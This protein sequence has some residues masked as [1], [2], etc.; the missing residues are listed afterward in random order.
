[1]KNKIHRLSVSILCLALLLVACGPQPSPTAA[2]EPSPAPT[3]PS[4]LPKTDWRLVVIGDSSL[5]RLG[6]AFA[7]QIENDLGVRVTLSDYA[8]P[9]LSA[10][11]VLED[12]RRETPPYRRLSP[13]AIEALRQANAV[14]MFVNPLHSVDPEHPLDTLACFGNRAPAIC[15]PEAFEPYIADLKA[16]WARILELRGD[17]PTILRAT[18]IYNPLVSPWREAGMFD[19]CTD[20]WQNLSDAARLAA[21]AYNIPFLSRFDAFNGPNHDEDPRGKGYIEADGEHPTELAAQFTAELLSQMGYEPVSPPPAPEPTATPQSDAGQTAASPYPLAEP[22]PYFTGKSQDRRSRTPA[23][24]TAG[25]ASPSG[26]RPCCPKGASGTG[27][28]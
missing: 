15:D 9:N 7:A 8:L 18:D 13:E 3:E 4:A 21:E 10:G 17:E 16:I 20:C 27:S 14:V 25:S 23:A 19:A 1:M 12:L 6:K 5:W 24:T 28:S 26:I 22:G 11:E 2:P